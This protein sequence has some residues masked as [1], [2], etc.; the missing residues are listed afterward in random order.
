MTVPVHRRPYAVFLSHAHADVDLVETLHT[1]LHDTAG[2][3]VWLDS[4]HLDGGT[5]IRAGLTEGIEQCRGMLILATK[6]ALEKGWVEFEVDV[7]MDERARSRGDFRV[8][9]LRV[10]GAPVDSLVRGLSWIDVNSRSLDAKTASAILRAFYPGDRH[11]DPRTSRDVYVSASWRAEDN[12][13][14]IAVCRQLRREGLRLIGDSKD[15]KGFRADRIKTVI[16][17]CGAFACV[18]PFR[19]G[20]SVA[21]STGGAYKY[22]VRELEIAISAG[23]PCV[24]VADDRVTLASS[25]SIQPL[26]MRQDATS[27]DTDVVTAIANLA[28]NWRAP[29]NPLYIFLSL[30]LESPHAAATHPAREI[31]ERITGMRTVVGTDVRDP[32]IDQGILHSIQKSHL[33]IADLVGPTETGFNLDVCIEVG[34]ARASGVSYELFARGP[35]RRPPFMLGRP[36]LE[37]YETELEFLGKIHRV[38]Q[39]YR[40]RLIDAELPS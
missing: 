10:D 38:V 14:A 17:S 15:Q 28:D 31:I 13:S 20:E 33:V 3:E 25:H 40:R 30:A 27:C 6:E 19:N 24:V 18:L 22:F 7:A 26:P 29:P 32:P 2:I 1:W 21:T 4:R 11:K 35:Q 16:E 34:M 37:A 36:Q 39:D 5:S 9:A 23:L 8:V 12:L